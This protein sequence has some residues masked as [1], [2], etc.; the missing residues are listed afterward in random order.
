MV[1][2]EQIKEL[3]ERT[4]ISIAQC[5]QALEEAGGDMEEALELLKAQGAVIAAKKAGRAL[6]AGVVSSY[7]HSNNKIGALVEVSSE[8]DFVAKNPEF[9]SF[10]DDIAMQVAAI[11]PADMDE[12]LIQPFIKDPSLT[13]SDLL[14]NQVQK[15][16][17]RI[18]IIRFARFDTAG[19]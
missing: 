1:T 17:E 14:K 11:P 4:G 12:L 18:A 19:K 13:V 8:T 5:K 7:I 6:G 2:T 10:A 9:H 16:G 3:R 15:F